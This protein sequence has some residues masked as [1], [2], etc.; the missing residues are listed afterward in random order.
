MTSNEISYPVKVI[1]KLLL[2]SDRRVQ[3]LAK[4]GILPKSDKGK[5]LLIP[6]VQAYIKYL[7]DNRHTNIDGE[8]SDIAGAR[9]INLHKARFEKFRADKTELEV[10]ILK[11]ELVDK[12]QVLKAWSDMVMAFRAKMLNLPKRIAGQVLSLQSYAEAE[13]LI[14]KAVYEALSELSEEDFIDNAEQHLDDAETSNEVD[15]T[16]AD[17][18][19]E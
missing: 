5:Y 10:Q 19:A 9:N 1:S 4:E 13:E 11:N 7:Q 17:S 12:T 18:D 16:A 14:K 2:I 3:Q 15:S 8:M 6:C